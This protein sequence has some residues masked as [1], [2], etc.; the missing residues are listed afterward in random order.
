MTST[1]LRIPLRPSGR[2]KPSQLPVA[3]SAPD[4]SAI[5]DWRSAMLEELCI[6]GSRIGWRA[7]MQVKGPGSFIQIAGQ[8]MQMHPGARLDGLGGVTD[9][10]A[11]FDHRF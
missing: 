8:I 10:N 6:S 2:R 1:R 4:L 7:G 5:G 3:V 11:E 9:A